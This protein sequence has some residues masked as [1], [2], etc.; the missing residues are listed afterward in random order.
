M[1]LEKL[2]DCH[3]L[4]VVAHGLNYIWLVK[5]VDTLQHLKDGIGEILLKG[6]LSYSN[7]NGIVKFFINGVISLEV[8]SHKIRGGY[9]DKIEGFEGIDHFFNK[10]GI[11]K[12]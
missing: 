11:A 8:E 5:N 9:S 4:M 10:I 12:Q 2:K 1:I 6:N 3:S 7:E